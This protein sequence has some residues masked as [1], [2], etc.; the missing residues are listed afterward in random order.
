[1]LV[2]EIL[3]APG[4]VAYSDRIVRD[5]FDGRKGFGI[6]GGIKDASHIRRLTS[7]HNSPMPTI[8]IAHQHLITARAL[9]ASRQERGM[10][11]YDVLDWSSVAAAS[12]IAAGLDAF[13]SKK[14]ANPVEE[15]DIYA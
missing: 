9:H 14:H 2:K 4:F 12:R 3:P 8:D 11:T 5:D 10:A 1:V 6:E 13:D 15:D 7:K